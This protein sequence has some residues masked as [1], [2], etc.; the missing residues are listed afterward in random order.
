MTE[1]CGDD[2]TLWVG[3]N[4]VGMTEVLA[5]SDISIPLPVIPAHAGIHDGRDAG[6]LMWIPASAGMTKGA[7]R[8]QPATAKAGAGIHECQ[9]SPPP[10]A[11]SVGIFQADDV[12]FAQVTA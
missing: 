12:V 3:R 7:F 8:A 1:R 4:A 9:A 10:S 11:P 5:Q 6:W 2:G